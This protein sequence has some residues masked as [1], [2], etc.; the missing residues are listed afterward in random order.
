MPA[1]TS[2]PPNF[3]SININERGAVGVEWLKQ[4]PSVIAD[5]ERRWDITI[6]P[7]F[8]G[9]SYN[10]AAPAVRADGTS[11]AIKIC[12]PDVEVVR[13]INALRHYGG[14][15]SV[16]LFG[17]D[18]DLGVLLM[19]QIQPGDMLSSIEDDTKTT[20][21]AASVMRQLRHPVPAE[22]SFIYVEDWARGM[23]RLR[24]E[25]NGGT[26]PF[27]L[28]LVDQ[29][30][31]L[32]AE[33]LPS[34]ATPIVLHG[35][36]H[37]FNILSA[38]RQP[39]LSIDPKGVIGEPAYEVG[40]LI[41]NPIPQILVEPNLAAILKRRIEQ[42]SDELALDRQ[43]IYGWSL[44]QAVLSAWW[45]YEDTEGNVDQ[46]FFKFLAFTEVLSSIRL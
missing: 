33:L 39:W 45:T 6:R 28:H 22:H 11:L 42:L 19:E 23:V 17:F 8:A 10:Y 27:P 3:V 41:R 14:V 2:F 15:G 12:C 32:F 29:A 1:P 26:G 37:H 36:L 13:E 38:Q 25:F 31:R 44:A 34:Q 40:A 5:C 16:E 7:P 18:L 46:E 30:E 43:R 4:L 9:L 35:D 21:I 24:N 20:S